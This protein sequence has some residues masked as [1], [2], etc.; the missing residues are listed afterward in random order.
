MRR[1]RFWADTASRTPT[2]RR[3]PAFVG[4]NYRTSVQE[5]IVGIEPPAAVRGLG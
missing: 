5:S 3:S 4:L 2:L 1:A